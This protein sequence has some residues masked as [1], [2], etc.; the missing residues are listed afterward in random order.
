MRGQDQGFPGRAPR[1]A[2]ARP[3]AAAT[4]LGAFV[5]SRGCDPMG[6][7]GLGTGAKGQA[8]G[9]S[10]GQTDSE[11]WWGEGTGSILLSEQKYGQGD[12]K[13]L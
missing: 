12:R 4:R 2:V 11:S 8:R 5:G 6:R 10:T 1:E 3:G 13:C 7:G 9:W